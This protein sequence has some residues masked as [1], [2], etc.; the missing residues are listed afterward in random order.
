MSKFAEKINLLESALLNIAD[1]DIERFA[2]ISCVYESLKIAAYRVHAEYH[3]R[4][5]KEELDERN[6]S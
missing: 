4:A 6:I 3:N 2:I 1:S 5:A